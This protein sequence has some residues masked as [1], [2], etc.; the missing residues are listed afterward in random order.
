MGAVLATSLKLEN[1]ADAPATPFGV[2]KRASARRRVLLSAKISFNMMVADC[3]IRNL[4]QNG[5]RIHAPTVLG[6]PDEVYL[7]ILREGLLVRA[8]R[9]WS[10]FPSFGLRFVEAEPI[11]RSTRPQTAPLRN[12][13]E[14]WLRSEHAKT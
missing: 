11:D 13:W 1:V 4:S 5:A 2:E 14:S 7:L 9:I 6:M 3:T 10:D 12:A 8:R